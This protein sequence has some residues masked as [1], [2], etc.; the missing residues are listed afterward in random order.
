MIQPSP[1]LSPMKKSVSSNSHTFQHI[2][3]D[4]IQIY[5]GI[6]FKIKLQKQNERVWKDVEEKDTAPIN[7]FVEEEIEFV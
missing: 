5:H 1:Y 6:L 7:Q 4:N 3:K 2:Y